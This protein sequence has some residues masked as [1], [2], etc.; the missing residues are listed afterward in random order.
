MVVKT[1]YSPDDESSEGMENNSEASE[2]QY[3]NVHEEGGDNNDSSWGPIDSLVSHKVLDEDPEKR[4][5]TRKR[6]RFDGKQYNKIPPSNS[7]K[8]PYHHGE[9]LIVEINLPSQLAERLQELIDRNE[10]RI[11]TYGKVKTSTEEPY[12]RCNENLELPGGTRRLLIDAD[13]WNIPDGFDPNNPTSLALA[14]RTYLTENGLG[15]LSQAGFTSL[16]SG[17]CLPGE[18]GVFRRLNG[19]LYFYLDQPT[20]LEELRQWGRAVNL[21]LRKKVID[22]AV[23]R[24]SQPDYFLPPIVE[25][26]PDPIANRV[27]WIPPA[28]QEA[29]SFIQFSLLQEEISDLSSDP[30]GAAARGLGGIENLSGAKGGNWIE[31]IRQFGNSGH[32]H[33]PEIIAASQYVF[34][35]GEK[36]IEANL[37]ACAEEI[38]REAW[39]NYLEAEGR[40]QKDDQA[41]YTVDHFRHSLESALNCG[42]GLPRDMARQAILSISDGPLLMGSRALDIMRLVAKTRMW[43]KLFAELRDH[44]KSFRLVTELNRLLNRGTDH[45]IDADNDNIPTHVRQHQRLVADGFKFFVSRDGAVFVQCPDHEGTVAGDDKAIF[46]R[47]ANRCLVNSGL[48]DCIITDMTIDKFLSFVAA[49]IA[50][51]SIH[52]VRHYRD[53]STCETWVDTGHDN[54]VFRITNGAVEIYDGQNRSGCPAIF[55]GALQAPF[56]TVTQSQ[57]DL[58]SLC[59][60][61]Y[62]PQSDSDHGGW[63]ANRKFLEVGWNLTE[64]EMMTIFAFMVYCILA[65]GE[66]PILHLIAKSAAGKSFLAASIIWGYEPRYGGHEGKGRWNHNFVVGGLPKDNEAMALQARTQFT[67]CA[68]NLNARENLTRSQALNHLTTLAT[69]VAFTARRLYSQTGTVRFSCVAPQIITGTAELINLPKDH[70]DLLTRIYPIKVQPRMSQG[71]MN[72]HSVMRDEVAR[73]AR[74]LEV[75]GAA[76]YVQGKLSTTMTSRHRI[77]AFGEVMDL[78]FPGLSEK[79]MTGHFDVLERRAFETENAWFKSF[80]DKLLAQGIA[81]WTGSASDIQAMTAGLTSPEMIGRT[82]TG[83]REVIERLYGVKISY[84]RDSKRR[85]WFIEI[86]PRDNQGEM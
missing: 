47:H 46:Y 72:F 48:H 35:H 41:Q 11:I 76:A 86:T 81:S 1:T 3:E 36:Y 12:R 29:E 20:T 85:T 70:Q 17:G 14:I 31:T 78:L 10:S 58:A 13:G 77:A 27:G 8:H 28:D 25:G 62:F 30:N 32:C 50:V 61:I 54:H 57:V 82:L 55:S 80:F 34:E 51:D 63:V 71:R 18:D 45:S 4:A 64:M 65:L 52:S 7:D 84:E 33:E 38:H 26:G 43:G 79:W 24:L 53:D 74:F 59:A 73:T 2:S 39:K 83:D 23:Y 69:G 5:R 49:S 22:P 6:V 40:S 67:S 9:Q 21:R 75:L 37:N 56:P 68:D 42:F 16:L 66:Y 60:D 19:H 44:Y 15:C